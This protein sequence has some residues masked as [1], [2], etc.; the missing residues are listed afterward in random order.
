[1]RDIFNEDYREG[2]DRWS[3]DWVPE[4]LKMIA[5]HEDPGRFL[6]VGVG[7]GTDAIFMAENGYEVTAVDVSDVSIDMVK[8]KAEEKNLE[9]KTYDQDIRDFDFEGKYDVI[10]SIQTL[11]FLSEED[12]IN[13]IDKIKDHTK[14]GGINFIT[15]AIK[16]SEIGH[17]KW[18]PEENDLKELYKDWNIMG[19]RVNEDKRSCVLGARK[20]RSD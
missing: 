7:N 18:I 15:T 2:K 6:D 19:Y 20:P 16:G 12:V 13:I 8:K 17:R 11:H 10:A 5:E 14:E 9:I 3:R 4:E 1:M